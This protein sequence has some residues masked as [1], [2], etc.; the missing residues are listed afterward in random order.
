VRE[1]L[2]LA[3]QR[4][5]DY[6]LFAKYMA[7]TRQTRTPLEI[8]VAV[9]VLFALVPQ[10]HAQVAFAP[11]NY[12][13]GGRPES[14]IAAD[15]N[16]DG[17]PDLICANALDDTLSVLTN[18]G[19]GG[20]VLACTL[21]VGGYPYSVTAADVNNDGKVDLICANAGENSLSVLTNDGRG[22]FSLSSTLGVGNFPI[23]I[24]TASVNGNSNMD[25][26]C[27]NEFDGTLSVLTNDGNG[28]FALA[29]TLEVGT[30][31]SSVVAVDINA[32]GKVDL[33]CA[34]AGGNTLSVLTNDGSGGFALSSTPVVDYDPEYLLATDVNDDGKVDL[35][36]GNYNSVSL[37][38]LTNDGG[39]GFTLAS[40][41]SLLDQSTRMGCPHGLTL[42][43]L[44]GNGTLDLICANL[45]D[46]T[47]QIFTNTGSG[48]FALC[49]MLEVGSGPVS[50]SAADVNG[51]GKVDLISA[52]ADNTL[53]VFIA[54]P[55]LAIN[56][57]GSDLRVS[58]PSGWTNWTLQQNSNLMTTN[59]V[60]SGNIS[61]NG[62]N[63][64]TTLSSSVGNLFF[65]LCYP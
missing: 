54:V 6:L 26:I 65:R 29:S 19:I 49:S 21:N 44:R 2:P 39:G 23:S 41:V 40:T 52:D 34:N 27:A 37:S 14:A 36:S 57:L 48:G 1:L 17:K 7:I 43:D 22:G 5:G 53:S 8:L 30:Y 18:N 28:G 31:P 51:D 50:V 59:W 10:L 58:W 42:A 32:D 46:G 25:L 62:T 61:D 64:S 3:L 33:I 13:V 38:V 4:F 55:T 63:K 35:I 20:F 47:L 9:A 45:C 16:G 15:V 60:A 24:T 56:Q 12:G 11:V